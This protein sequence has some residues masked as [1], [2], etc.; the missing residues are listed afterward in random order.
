MGSSAVSVHVVKIFSVDDG[1]LNSDAELIKTRTG[2]RNE[3]SYEV[4]FSASA[5][6]GNPI[7]REEAWLQYDAKSHTISI[8]LIQENG[9][10]TSKKIRYRFTGTYFEKI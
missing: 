5:N 1:M 2:I 4:D 7:N 3:L 6:R 8:P 10:L 9:R